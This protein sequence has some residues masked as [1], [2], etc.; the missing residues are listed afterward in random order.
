MQNATTIGLNRTGAQMS[1]M[2][3]RSM[4]NYA[5][6]HS[7]H[8]DDT[9]EDSSIA[10][11][12]SDYAQEADRIGSVPLPGTVTGAVTTGL[13][14]LTGKKPEVLIDKIGERLAFERTGVRIYQ[15]LMDKVAAAEATRTLP[16]ALADLEHIRDEEFEHLQM[17]TS[18]LEAMG[19]DPTAQ[20]PCAD[21]AAVAS[22]GVL[23]VLTDPRTTIAQCLNAV[24]T[25]ELTDDAGWDLLL[26]LSEE[27]G[28][29]D[30]MLAGFQKAYRHEEEHVERIREWLSQMVLEEAA[31]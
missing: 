10:G 29:G 20:T 12:R 15:A 4:E 9:L 14:K 3:T 17:L 6:Q 27:A 7:P 28:R 22:G 21:V 13:A 5:D 24:L 30:E 1:P 16:F 2:A 25:A 31:A 19:A 23:Q 18:A 26:Q 8:H 11:L